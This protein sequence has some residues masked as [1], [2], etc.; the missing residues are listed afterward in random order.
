MQVDIEKSGMVFRKAFVLWLFILVGLYLSSLYSYLLFHSIVELFSIAIA[1]CVFMIA[2]NSRQLISNN[3]L[4]FV[5][6]AYLFM[7]CIDLAHTLTYKGM[8]IFSGIDSNISTQLWIAGRYMQSISLLI[9]ILFF[10]KKLNPN[11]VFTCYLIVTIFVLLS[12]FSV[13]V[14]PACFEEGKGLTR[15]KIYSEYLI[16]FMFIGTVI[17]LRHYKKEFDENVL[18][19]IVWSA[20]FAIGSE[21]FFTFY[22]D[23]Y[24]FSNLIGHFFK[25]ASFYCMYKA[26]IKTGL[27]KPYSILLRD[28]KMS[29]DALKKHK[30]ELENIVKER[31]EE[32]VATNAQIVA[33]G[34]RLAEAENIER[35]RISRELHDLVGQNLTALGINLNILRSKVPQEVS[36]VAHAR[37]N[38]SLAL[39]SETTDSIRDVMTRLRPPVLDDYGLLSALRWHSEQFSSRT[40]I[41]VAIEGEEVDLKLSI[42]IES[43]LFRIT[44]EALNNVAKHARATKTRVVLSK[45][46]E[47]VM[48]IIEDNGIG[49]DSNRL[50]EIKSVGKWGLRNITERAVSIGG[51][52]DIES[53]PGEGTRII[54]EVTV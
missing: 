7:G 48:L 23:V 15:F 12:I 25:V 54:V 41:D 4:L 32:L 50:A 28:L 1:L 16:S 51:Q 9:A 46:D 10:N 40:G 17:L 22:I 24:G 31:T 53:K 44:Q 26:M 5:G 8:N 19:L 35:Q 21:L 6:I 20:L 38:D 27:E 11:V 13:N 37:I 49:F 33:L 43:A 3:Y 39:I 42:H 18:H 52:C 30:E 47:K 29:G 36:E 2:W 45:K 14:F 34:R